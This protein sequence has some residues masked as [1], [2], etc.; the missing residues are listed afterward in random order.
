[1]NLLRIVFLTLLFSL[2]FVLASPPGAQLGYVDVIVQTDGSQEA[3]TQKIEALGGEVRKVYRNVPAL[4]VRIVATDLNLLAASAGVVKVEKDRLVML[5]PLKGRPVWH[6]QIGLEKSPHRR[7]VPA[8]A[9]EVVRSPKGYANVLL[10]GALE[11]WEQTGFGEGSIVAVVDTGVAPNAAL[12]HAVIGAP[13]FPNG[14]SVI[15]DGEATDFDNHWHGTMVAGVIAS[16]VLLELSDPAD[17][18]YMAIAA[19]MPELL[20]ADPS[21][22]LIV[23]V[24]GQAPGAKIYPVKVFPKNGDGTPHSLIMEAL[25]HV[26]TLKK[27]GA[28]DIDIVNMSLGGLTLYEGGDTFDRFVEELVKANILVVCAAGNAGPVPNSLGSPGTSFG[29]LAVGALDY[30]LP[31]RVF[32]EFLGNLFGFAPGMGR[33]MRPGDEVRVVNFSS[34][35]P[36][37]DGR[38]GPEITALGTWNFGLFP[39]NSVNWVTGTSFS[40]PTVAGVAALLNASWETKHGETAPAKLEAALLKS[41]NRNVVGGH[42]RRARDQGNGV[43]DAPGALAALNKNS[44]RGEDGDEDSE[45]EEDGENG[46]S[47]KLKANILDRPV[48]GKTRTWN[49]GTVSLDPGETYD[50]ILEVNEYTSKVTVE[51]YDIQ[52]P[53]NFATSL[54]PNALEVQVQSAKRSDIP[55]VVGGYLLA[56]PYGEPLTI[57]IEDGAWTLAGDPA[58]IAIQPMEPGLIK[59]TLAGDFVNEHPIKFKAR[60]TRVNDRKPL[61]GALAKGAINNG[62]TFVFPIEIPAGI[63]AATFDL[64]WKRDWSQFPTSDVDLLIFR[65]VGVDG[66]ELVSFDAA[67]VNAPE[68][69]VLQN[70]QEGTYYLLV[71]GF[72]VHKPDYYELFMKLE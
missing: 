44:S 53:D 70:P 8:Q 48:K 11:I 34:R 1:M 31:S 17:P 6:Q 67:T 55:P 2:S 43:V 13:G 32:Y 29:S 23:P 47:G 65:A 63:S 4:S 49:S 68:R 37:S 22:S 40:S 38:A 5:D 12:Q 52:A 72:E 35:G 46:S 15:P 58:P 60:V 25:D 57:Q 61:R 7:I 56:P 45:D 42:W 59:V 66:A 69:A 50:A 41:A 26:L 33:I 27:T 71:N 30:P 54:V 36:L 10:T 64:Q 39:D 20:P 9:A 62:D 19:H 24:L 28:L 21:E 18:L 16:A 51:V 3:V 14:Y